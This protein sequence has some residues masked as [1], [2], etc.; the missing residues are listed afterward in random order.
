[1]TAGADDRRA[2]WEDELNR[3]DT[4]AVVAKLHHMGFGRGAEVR[5][6]V[7]E[8]QD[9]T[10]GF[11]EEWLGRKEA[12]KAKREEE[13]HAATRRLAKIALGVAIGSLVVSLVGNVVL[14]VF[15]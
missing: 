8:M 11:V 6:D 15:W 1:M 14:K 7:R 4:T 3:L 5:L 9:P 10:R 13:R 2:R 12:E